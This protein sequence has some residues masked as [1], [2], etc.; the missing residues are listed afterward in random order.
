MDGAISY[1]DWKGNSYADAAAKAAAA[2]GRAS[3]A[4]RR[5]LHLA[6]QQV[7]LVAM[8][9]TAVGTWVD[10][11]DTT[12]RKERPKRAVRRRRE[13]SAWLSCS[14]RGKGKDRWCEVCRWTNRAGECPGSILEDAVKANEL[15][16]QKGLAAHDLVAI[17]PVL[18]SE[19]ERRLPL[20]ACTRCGFTGAARACSFGLECKTPPSAAGSAAIARL[21]A[22]LAPRI[23]SEVA[24]TLRR[25]GGGEPTAAAEEVGAGPAPPPAEPISG[26]PVARGEDGGQSVPPMRGED[27][28]SEAAEGVRGGDG[29]GG[30]DW[31]A[32]GAAAEAAATPTTPGE[33][34]ADG[35]GRRDASGPRG[36]EGPPARRHQGPPPRAHR[37]AG[38]GEDE[39][40]DSAEAAESGPR[41]VEE[42]PVRRHQGPLPRAHRPAGGGEE[43]EG[44]AA[45][46]AEAAEAARRSSV[47]AS[48][49]AA[50]RRGCDAAG[51]SD[52][53]AA[54][55]PRT[56]GPQGA[57]PGGAAGLASDPGGGGPRVASVAP[58]PVGAAR[59]EGLG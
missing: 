24:V 4:D 30:E 50:Y 54:R 26:S 1:R 8:W 22:G 32:A 55:T 44:A 31:C 27:W 36:V 46:S 37:P 17:A 38:G 28:G 53:A 20:V 15:L 18:D 33:G 49:L 43:G 40:A 39:G 58:V 41:G 9:C 7:D 52:G 16:V 51:L 14:W 47:V 2:Q 45:G 23:A 59:P 5:K 35:E 11:S 25:L 48:L 34:E 56:G 42:P 3:A 29:A 10:G 21:R 57:K 6:R 12:H 19:L 13:A